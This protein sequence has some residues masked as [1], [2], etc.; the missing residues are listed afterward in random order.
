MHTSKVPGV[1]CT[2]NCSAVEVV[3]WEVLLLLVSCGT[4][5]GMESEGLW[6]GQLVEAEGKKKGRLIYRANERNRGRKKNRDEMKAGDR[7]ILPFIPPNAPSMS[8]SLVT[9][10]AVRGRRAGRF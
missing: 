9:R 8:R 3:A 1:T 5:S 4:K 6:L 10:S 2:L 7:K